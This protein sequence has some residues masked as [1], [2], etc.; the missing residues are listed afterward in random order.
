MPDRRTR[1]HDYLNFKTNKSGHRVPLPLIPRDTRAPSTVSLSLSHR[2]IK[3]QSQSLSSHGPLLLSTLIFLLYLSLCFRCTS[4]TYTHQ[5]LPESA[6]SRNKL[7]STL[8]SYYALF[9]PYSLSFNIYPT[10]CS[11]FFLNFHT[12]FILSFHF[13]SLKIN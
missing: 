9:S 1:I 5:F 6:T 7:Y 4:S 2:V 3:W 8:S 12:Y 10:I 13:Y 11:F